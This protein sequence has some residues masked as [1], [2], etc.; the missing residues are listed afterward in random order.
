MRRLTKSILIAIALML[1][2]C[3]TTTVPSVG[4]RDPG[5]PFEPFNRQVH[6]FNRSADQVVV[7][8]LAQGYAAVTPAPVR[9]G[10]RNFF[11]NLRAP[12]V[13]INLLLQGRPGDSLE[14]FERFF[15][16]TVYGLGGLFDLAGKADLP[17]HDADLGMTFATWGWQD[18]RFV[19][20]P[21]LGP[22]T[23]RD[24]LGLA[25]DNFT[26]P[27]WR[28][29][30]EAGGHGLL[31]LNIVQIRA[32][33]L[34]LDAQLEAAFDEYI[35]LRDGFLQ[36]RQF[37]LKGGEAELPDYESFLDEQDWDDWE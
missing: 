1:S 33:L 16:N 21:L 24:G 34:P 18:S 27:A 10:I 7:R 13:M 31:A 36:R 30:R 14:Q 11:S 19:M 23:L 15:V 4:E 17:E 35:F 29:A 22:S 20:L 2:G 5:D 26:N 3:A 28:S 9:S 8:P 37:M 32:N 25:G 6:A 12:A